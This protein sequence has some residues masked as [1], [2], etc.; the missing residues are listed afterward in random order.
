MK[1]SG[2]KNYRKVIWLCV[3]G[4]VVFMSSSAH[5]VPR[6]AYTA[7]YFASSISI[8]L[9][10]S[11]TGIMRHRAHVPTVKSPST[12]ILHPS[13]KFLYAVS[14]VLDKIAIYRVNAKT[15]ALTEI[16]DSRVDA[17]VRSAF[18]LRISPDGKFLYVPGR[19]TGN[20]VVHR[21]DQNTGALTLLSQN[22]LSTKGERARF[23]DV[24][25]DGRFIYVS[26]AFTNTIAA[27]TMDADAESVSVIDGMPFP[28]SH[29]PQAVIVH[30]SGKFL[31]VA[32]WQAAEI[33]TYAI[34]ESTGRL[35]LIPGPKAE[36]GIF[37]FN[38]SVHPSG[39]YLYIANW[40]SSNI[41]AFLINQE[42]GALS[43]MP[44]SPIALE[45]G[46][47][48]VTVHLDAAG[49]H[50]Y[51]PD[52]DKMDITVFDVNPDSGQ[53][54]NPRRFYSRPGVRGMAILEGDSPVQLSA[55]WIIAA[56]AQAKTINSYEVGPAPGQLQ[57]RDKLP[58]ENV[59][60]KIALHSDAG[61]VFVTNEQ[62]KRI[63]VYAI[64]K[65]GK[66]SKRADSPMELEG[67]VPVGLRVNARG[68]HLYVITQAPNQYLAFA[69][70]VE[71]GRL[72]GVER[73]V[74][75][76][77]S[78][79][80]QVIASP[81]E[82]LTF[83]L[84]SVG[85][86]VFAYRYLYA[87]EPVMFELDQHG[88]PFSMAEGLVAMV[89]DPTGRYGLVV[90]SETASVSSYAMPGRWGPL[91]KV[92]DSTVSVG[93]RPVSVTM[94]PNGRDVYV[95]DAGTPQIH[96][97]QLDSRD[98]ILK[99]SAPAIPLTATPAGLAID[100]AGRFAY[101]WYVSRAGV[102]RYEIDVAQGSLTHPKE[103]LSG[104]VPSALAFTAVVQ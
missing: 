44:G 51:V 90:S 21:I 61:L 19:F 63:D 40:A 59:P 64:S 91:K 65:D 23:V 102:T 8:Y 66:L 58:L 57:L 50:A 6:F 11:D 25:P 10:D 14:Q 45:D 103:V 27:F 37:P 13:G 68:S 99:A 70:D 47:S 62:A 97:L 52:Y 75:P 3:V 18:Q 81:A 84:D 67:G 60:G 42:T 24:T 43:P 34:N 2:D 55:Q 9:V 89:V 77:D 41:S 31:F 7:N 5:A 94:S 35:S 46:G 85:N 71:K 20:L 53:L 87:A 49:Q 17:G 79:P 82:R 38:G 104:V 88:S 12:V 26:N 95:L 39:K 1:F 73:V 4:F 72:Q 92:E 48:P 56:D 83:V 30:P 86:R 96:Q 93:Q 101:I 54:N 28:A 22:N 80:I 29:A 32:N 74:L 100:P 15:G 76:A 69:I 16:D 36:A 33:S 78:K 98:G